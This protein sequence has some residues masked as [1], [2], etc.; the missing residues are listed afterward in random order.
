MPDENTANGTGAEPVVE[1]HEGKSLTPESTEAQGAGSHPDGQESKPSPFDKDPRWQSARQAEKTLQGLLTDLEVEDVDELKELLISGKQVS[2]KLDP[3]KIDDLITKAETLERYEAY[4]KT[5]EEVARRAEEEPEVTADRLTRE[6][7]EL[8]REQQARKIAEEN[9][10]TL[11]TYDHSVKS[12]IKELLPDLPKDQMEFVLLALGVDNPAL[13]IEI[14]DKVAVGRT[15]KAIAKRFETLK[16]NII[17]GYVEGKEKIPT[18]PKGGG[19]EAPL[20]NSGEPKTLK[21]SRKMFLGLAG[22]LFNQ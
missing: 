22:R 2:G 19:G 1:T 21:E 10:R 9:K 15:V 8:K 16:Q 18:V 20:S 11:E 12:G 13:D 4:W 17:K 5:Q 3:A 6:N 14:K 7:V